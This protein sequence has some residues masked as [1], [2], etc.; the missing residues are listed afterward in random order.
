MPL[1]K[2]TNKEFMSL[3]PNFEQAKTYFEDRLS[4]HGASARGVD[5]NS[6]TAQ[7]LRFAQLAKVVNTELPFSLLDY[8]CGYGALGSY[9][10]RTGRPMQQY[11]GYDVLESMVEKARQ[12]FLDQASWTFTSHFDDLQPVDFAVASGIF[13][14]KLDIPFDQ[15]TSYVVAEL[16]KINRLANKGFSFNL[17]TKYSDAE[18]MRPHLYYADP[19]FFFDTCKT[20]FSRN[21]ALLHDYEVYDFTIIVRK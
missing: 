3:I 1:D 13:N 11:V 8:G 6:E 15:W 12:V 9:L 17:L 21:V 5:W 20:H 14:L 7:E 4:A 18:Y 16:E 19:C 2:F 10:L